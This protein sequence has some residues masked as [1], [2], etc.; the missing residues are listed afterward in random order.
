MRNVA[1]HLDL[2]SSQLE[3]N[4]HTYRTTDLGDKGQLCCKL[5]TQETLKES[6]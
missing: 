1:F 4:M 5:S 2:Y 3:R 6:I